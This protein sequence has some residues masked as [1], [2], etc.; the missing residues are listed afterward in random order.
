MF[1]VQGCK[2]IVKSYIEYRF[3]TIKI[4]D[5]YV[6]RIHDFRF[7]DFRYVLVFDYALLCFNPI[8]AI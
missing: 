6:I 7:A 2:K 8:V 3:Y 1:N 5:L 4:F